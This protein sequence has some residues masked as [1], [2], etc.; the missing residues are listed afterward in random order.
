MGREPGW[1]AGVEVTVLD[2]GEDTPN[3]GRVLAAADELTAG[4]G[5]QF[6]LTTPTASPT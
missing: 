1:P 2:T 5:G 6:H 3:G 4:P